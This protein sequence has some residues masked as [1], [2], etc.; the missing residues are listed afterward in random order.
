MV[1]VL[2]VPYDL[3][4]N[5]TVKNVKRFFA[6]TVNIFYHEPKKASHGGAEA[7]RHRGKITE[8][9]EKITEERVLFSLL[10]LRALRV[11]PSVSSVV[12]L[13]IS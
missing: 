2:P 12:Y 11:L 4:I 3:N 10:F 9:S 6:G 8:N 5:G 13:F 1:P 7:Q